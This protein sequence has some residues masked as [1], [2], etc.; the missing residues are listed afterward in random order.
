MSYNT[1]TLIRMTTKPTQ[2]N[3]DVPNFGKVPVCVERG[4]DGAPTVIKHRPPSVD[5]DPR[6]EFR[7][8]RIERIEDG[9]QIPQYAVRKQ[10]ILLLTGSQLDDLKAGRLSVSVI[11]DTGV[12]EKELRLT[13]QAGEIIVTDCPNPDGQYTVLLDWEKDKE[14]SRSFPSL[15]LRDSSGNVI[16]LDPDSQQ[17]N[18]LVSTMLDEDPNNRPARPPASFEPLNNHPI[19]S[20]FRPASGEDLDYYKQDRDRSNELTVAV[21]DTGLKFN[22]RNPDDKEPLIDPYVYRDAD[23]QERRFTLAYQEQP[24]TVCGDEMIDNHLGYCALLAYRNKTFIGEMTPLPTTT[25]KEFYLSTHVMNSPFDDFRL[26]GSDDRN[27]L[28]DA[29]HGTFVTAIIQQN[30]SDAPVLPVKIFDNIGFATL[31]DV[32]NGFNYVLQRCLSTNIRV[33]NISWVFGQ[34]NPLLRKKFEQLLSAGVMVIA[35]A[36]NEGQTSDRN[37]S[38]VQV[39]PACYSR[40]MPNVITVTSVRKTYLP[41]TLLSPKEDSFI[42]TVLSGAINLGLFNALEGVDDVLENV[43]PTAGYVAVENYS[44]E[45]VNVGV[46]S[47]FGYFRSPIWNNPIVRGSSFAC[48]FVAGFV[49]R[50][51]RT[52]PNLLALLKAGDADKVRQELLEAMNGNQTDENLKNEYVNGGYYLNGYAVD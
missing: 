22:L 8:E 2:V 24:G 15:E 9:N 49:I 31:F 42:G 40:E 45:Y 4:R 17:N 11:R 36:G 50:Q 16:E 43:L 38:N 18:F 25:E 7:N 27:S 21:I 20:D 44:T 28:Q 47:T 12:V 35:A 26:F 29:R 19:K 13:E 32:L 3:I 14:T 51:L 23:G 5:L 1:L 30:G 34:D 52:R 33:V 46:V 39:Y 10:K 48:A 6:L 37:L 41:T